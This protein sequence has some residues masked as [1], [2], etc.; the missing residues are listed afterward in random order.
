MARSNLLSTV[1]IFQMKAA[2]EK[3]S[4]ATAYDY[5]TAKMED[6]AGMDVILVGDS[7][8]AVVQGK[9]TTLSVTLENM[10]YHAEMVVRAVERAV[11][12]V[13]MPF[14][15]CQLGPEAAVNACARVVK[16]TDA[17]GVKIE[18]GASR[19]STIRAV[20]DAGIP[21]MAHCG[22]VP[23]SVKALGGYRMQRDWEQLLSDALAVQEA[24]AFAVVLE[25]V[26]AD[27]AQRLTKELRIPTIGIGSGS[28]C[29]GQVLVFHDMFNFAAQD[30]SQAPKHAR[31]YC[32]LHAHIDAG[33]RQYIK[34]VKEGSF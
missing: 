22:L 30:P 13:D 18:G 5:P 8:G 20:V 21:V 11:T 12:I 15:Y 26:Q 9:Q 4:V 31:L 23:Q 28:N 10:I 33:L 6:Q 16:E 27:L 19:A 14:P 32:D 29:D 34:E 7:L 17:T 3:I 2:G 1:K 24:G 25:C